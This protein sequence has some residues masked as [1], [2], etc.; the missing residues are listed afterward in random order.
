MPTAPTGPLPIQPA[1]PSP[2]G[3]HG[4][5]RMGKNP[6]TPSK[7]REPPAHQDCAEAVRRRV[8]ADVADMDLS[9]AQITKTNRFPSKLKQDKAKP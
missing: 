2:N 3:L 4:L 1:R 7:A 5:S 9:T 8:E 6:Q